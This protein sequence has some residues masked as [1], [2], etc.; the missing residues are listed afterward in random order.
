[1]IAMTLRQMTE[2]MRGRLDIPR[3]GVMGRRVV[4]DSREV[5]PGD[6]FF[7]L[8][9]ENHDGHAFVRQ[10]LDHGAALCVC[11]ASRRGEM[12]GSDP[13]L[14]AWVDDVTVA[15]GRLAAYYR[16]SVMNPATKVIAVTGSNGKTT[17]KR[18][19]DHVLAG[20]R[21]GHCSPKSF[22]NQ[23][24]VPLTILS[25]DA[26]DDYLV[27]EIGT[28]APG[29]VAALGTMSDADVGVITSIGEAHLEGLGGL[30]GVAVEKASLLRCIRRGGLG[31]VNI[32]QPSLERHLS[33]LPIDL[34]RIGR[35]DASDV[36]IGHVR[37][38]IHGTSFTLDGAHRVEL[39]MPGAHH[40][41]NAAAAYAVGRWFRVEPADIAARLRT[42]VPPQGRTNVSEC[43]GV[44]LVDDAYNANPASVAAAIALLASQDKGRRVLV[45]GD[46][47]ELGAESPNLHRRVVEDARS[48][49]IDVLVGVGPRMTSAALGLGAEPLG[50]LQVL[51]DSAETACGALDGILAPGDTVLVKGSRGVRLDHVVAH[52]QGRHKKAA[53]VA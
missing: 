46:M 2:A 36:A 17:T 42:F 40:A 23:I 30:D 34:R 45:L 53:A 25:A 31:V 16:R 10:A 52:V 43:G 7:A 38:T 26:D 28:N 48:A 35:R 37:G 5:R 29:E 21:K 6:V 49:G 3:P 24:G 18:M 41:T 15:L 1:M 8:R 13:M 22:N 50:R 9:G 27:L 32:D 12:R 20:S 39:P 33:G 11:E 4:T 51:C 44:T 47:L 14:C 19:I